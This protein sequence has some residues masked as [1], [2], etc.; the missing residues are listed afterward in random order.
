MPDGK[1]VLFHDFGEDE[2][3][4]A[5]LT[6]NAE[7]SVMP[8]LERDFGLENAHISPDGRWLAYESHASGTFDVYVRPF[9]DVESGRWQ[10]SNGGGL[11]PLWGPDGTE[12]FIERDAVT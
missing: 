4:F 11:H 6:L 9:P 7:Q 10:I 2:P 1:A 3:D 8:L 5:V 12:L